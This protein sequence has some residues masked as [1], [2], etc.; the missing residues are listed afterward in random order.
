MCIGHVFRLGAVGV[1]YTHAT[2]FWR[3]DV[4]AVLS[5]RCPVSSFV[6]IEAVTSAVLI[7]SVSGTEF[8]GAIDGRE[9]GV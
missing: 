4:G 7:R 9:H 5:I 6:V 3:I 8:V 2:G 1:V